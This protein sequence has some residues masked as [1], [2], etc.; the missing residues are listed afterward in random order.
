MKCCVCLEPIDKNTIIMT[1]PCTHWICPTC[2]CKMIKIW[3]EEGTTKKRCPMC[4]VLLVSN[5]FTK[6]CQYTMIKIIKSS[7]FPLVPTTEFIQENYE[8][9]LVDSLM[10]GNLQEAFK[11]SFIIKSNPQ[12]WKIHS[13]L[14]GQH[15][16]M[17][18]R[19]HWSAVHGKLIEIL[20][21]LLLLNVD[22]FT[23]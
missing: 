20:K 22:I 4:R 13:V 9:M 7:I 16:T 23:V 11:F 15:F 3:K 12:M 5:L 10:A 1:K 6:Q 21:R 18:R 19:S 8:Q 14:Y 17:R 2:S